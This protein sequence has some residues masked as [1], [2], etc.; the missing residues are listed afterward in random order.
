MTTHASI[1][2]L[3]AQVV[4]MASNVIQICVCSLVCLFFPPLRCSPIWGRVVS[5]S[6]ANHNLNRVKSLK[7]CGH[8][9]ETLRTMCV[10]EGGWLGKPHGHKMYPY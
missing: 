2:S 7:F 3:S 9:E 8:L 1:F 6:M 10:D 4:P 5:K